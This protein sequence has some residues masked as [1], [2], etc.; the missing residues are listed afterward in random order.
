VWAVRPWP[1]GLPSR[2]STR[3]LQPSAA[4]AQDYS[5]DLGVHAGYPPRRIRRRGHRR[6]RC[7]PA[8]PRAELVGE[9]ERYEDCYGLC[10]V[11][12]P[13]GTIVELAEQIG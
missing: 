6:C 10:D 3:R 11:R 13:D 4:G 9:L 5:P 12:G 7:R 2:V 8:S 1:L